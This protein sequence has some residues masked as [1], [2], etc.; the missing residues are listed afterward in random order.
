MSFT[1]WSAFWQMGG[2]GPYVWGA[3]GITVI[4]LGGLLV[5]YLWR[6]RRLRQQL[7]HE[8]RRNQVQRLRSK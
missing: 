6:A 4:V 7:A 2:Y 3:Y 1:S 8:L 5:G